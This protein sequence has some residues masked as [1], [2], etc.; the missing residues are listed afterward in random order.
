MLTRNR[1]RSLMKQAEVAARPAAAPN[2]DEEDACPVCYDPLPPTASSGAV[3]CN[4]CKHSVCGDCDKSLTNTGHAQC[5]MCRAPRRR[6][7]PLPL[8][9]AIHA[10]HCS[11]TACDRPQCAYAKLVLLRI[12]E[13]TKGCNTLESECKVCKLWRVL[14]YS[15]ARLLSSP[16]EEGRREEG[17]TWTPDQVKRMLLSHVRQCRNRRCNTCRKLRE[18]LRTR[19]YVIHE[20]QQ[21]EVRSDE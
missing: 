1:R 18:R 21:L 15:S 5:P 17:R 14:N 16:D 2:E 9:M 20:Q 12:E 4:V 7:P 13:H 11:N 3:P 8:H 19:G 10:F 6:A